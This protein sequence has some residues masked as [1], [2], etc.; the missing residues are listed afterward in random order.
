MQHGVKESKVWV[1]HQTEKIAK[2]KEQVPV[3]AI[4]KG[5]LGK[6]T[7]LLTMLSIFVMFAY[8]GLNLWVPAYLSLSTAQGG[9]ALGASWTTILLVTM[10][11]GTF[12]GYITFGYVADAFG[13]RPTFVGYLLTAAVL[14]L[15]YIS[16]HNPWLL[17]IFG[18]MVAFCGT[19]VFSGFGAVSAEIFP[20]S[21]R[22][23]AQGLTFNGGRMISGFAPFVVGTL[24][25][26]HGFAWAF[27]LTAVSLALA[28]SMWLWIPE[29]R[30]RN[31]S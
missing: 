13:R 5:Q 14:V 25:Q 8:W 28:A 12:F 6:M 30:G 1:A 26:T 22:A 4:F 16:T 15:V 11:T 18:P 31:L 10:Q 20:T 7:F 9:L 2:P 21:V 24:A 23:T 17:M 19:G 3:S 27:V 29:T